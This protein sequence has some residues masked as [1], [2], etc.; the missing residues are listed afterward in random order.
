MLDAVV[1]IAFPFCIFINYSPIHL[2]RSIG[3][4]EVVGKATPSTALLYFFHIIC[5]DLKLYFIK[6]KPFL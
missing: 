3:R 4:H 1:L 2:A 6:T 5:M